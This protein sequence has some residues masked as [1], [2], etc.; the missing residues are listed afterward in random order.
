MT[1][2]AYE[3]AGILNKYIEQIPNK[4]TLLFRG[5]E[6]AGWS[7]DSAATRRLSLFRHAFMKDKKAKYKIDK[8]P[9]LPSIFYNLLI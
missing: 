2:E 6:D 3:A 7:L 4:G 9:I 5:Q 8:S 1:G